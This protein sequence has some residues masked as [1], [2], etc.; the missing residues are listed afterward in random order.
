MLW[1]IITAIFFFVW[2][3]IDTEEFGLG[4]CASFLGL[5]IGGIL[6]LAL[7]SAIGCFLPT[8]DVVEE[9]TICALNDSSKI[10][11]ANYLFSGYIEEKLVIRY[12]I[13]TDKGKHIEEI[14]SV[15]NVYINEGDYEPMVK[16]IYQEFAEEWY[17][18][19]ALPMTTKEYIFY[20]PNNTV[21]NEYNIDLN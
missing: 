7:G 12:V 19:I 13:N 14:P 11:G 15:K 2:A 21:T 5:L 18:W 16:T 4:I 9:Q 17:Y 1:V 3:L 8:V 20:V 10:E 6:Y